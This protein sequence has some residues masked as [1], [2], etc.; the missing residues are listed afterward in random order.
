MPPWSESLVLLKCKSCPA[1]QLRILPRFPMSFR[2]EGGTLT[3]A[4]ALCWPA[5]GACSLGSRYGVR[6]RTYRVACAVA[7]RTRPGCPSALTH[8]LLWP[9]LSHSFSLISVLATPPASFLSLTSAR[10]SPAS[11]SLHFYFCQE[12]S[13]LKQLSLCLCVPK[14]LLRSHFGG[15]L[16]DHPY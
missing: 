4:E 7:A 6:C 5:A 10:P 12:E 14:S 15:T 1:I 2:G 13:P 16:T 8:S 3:M 11:G 9:G